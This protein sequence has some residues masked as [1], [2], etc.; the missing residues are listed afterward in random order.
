MG[1][2]GWVRDQ[3]RTLLR[4]IIALLQCLI[5]NGLAGHRGLDLSYFARGFTGDG[6]TEGEQTL[7]LPPALQLPQ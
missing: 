5:P 3:I 4:V 7:H 6:V 1:M 2:D